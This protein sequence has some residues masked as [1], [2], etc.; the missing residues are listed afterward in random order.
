MKLLIAAAAALALTGCVSTGTKVDTAQVAQFKNGETTEAEIVKALGPPQSITDGPTGRTLV[1][2]GT[3]AQA[4]ASSY[5][6]IVGAFTGGATG[7][8]TVVV[9]RIGKDGKLIDATT[10]TTNT[11]VRTGVGATH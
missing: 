1:Y 6:P 4:K 7:S 2:V 8:S 9:L 10:N 11:D 5:I 3:H